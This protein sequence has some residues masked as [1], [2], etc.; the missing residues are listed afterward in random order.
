MASYFTFGYQKALCPLKIFL[1]TYL[2]ITFENWSVLHMNINACTNIRS[3]VRSIGRHFRSYSC[4]GRFLSLLC[5]KV[6]SQ[7][8]RNCSH[9]TYYWFHILKPVDCCEQ[10]LNLLSNF[11]YEN[12]SDYVRNILIFLILL[13]CVRTIILTTIG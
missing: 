2:S 9:V 11:F 8:S 6:D 1:P 5:T 12:S 10:P 13:I 7:E 3:A 4:R